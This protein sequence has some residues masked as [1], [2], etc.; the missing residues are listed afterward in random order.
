MTMRMLLWLE[1]WAG[2]LVWFISLCASFAVAP[3]ACSQQWHPL[4]PAI[5]IVALLLTA[6][7]GTIAWIQ[8]RRLGTDA[9]G[10]LG[11]GV[12]ADRTLASGAV[13]LNGAFCL[14]ILAQLTA[15][16]LLD[17]CQ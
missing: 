17:V 2:A 7:A 5:S 1:F 6:A 15:P 9:V 11:G 10:E 12:A 16:T 13:I 4:L 3:L 8:W 14:V